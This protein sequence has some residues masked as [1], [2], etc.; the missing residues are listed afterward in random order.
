MK[1]K[2]FTIDT[3]PRRLPNTFDVVVKE[4]EGYYKTHRRI[5]ELDAVVNEGYF[6]SEGIYSP[7]TRSC[8][9]HF[10]REYNDGQ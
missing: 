6:Y 9:L 1:I 10:H 5:P 4:C 2:R 7:Y 3:L 8:I